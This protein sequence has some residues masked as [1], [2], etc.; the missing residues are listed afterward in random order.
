MTSYEAI[1]IDGLVKSAK[2]VAPAKAGAQNI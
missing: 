1:K 2:I